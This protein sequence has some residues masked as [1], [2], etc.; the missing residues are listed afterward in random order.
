MTTARASYDL[1]LIIPT[2]DEFDYMRRSVPLSPISDVDKGYWFEFSLP[3]QRWGVAHV[4]FDMGLVTT[5]T[6]TGRLLARFSPD[7]LAVVGTGGGLSP[8]LALGDV[9]VGSVIQEYMKAAK[10]ASDPAKG[11][12]IKPSG[13]SW[14]LAE[15]LRNFANHFKYFAK[16]NHEDWL[17]FARIRA[18]EDDI[19]LATTPG[20]RRQP[21]YSLLPIASGDLVVTDPVFKDWLISHD[22]MRSVIEMEAAGAAHA[23]QAHDKGVAL[24]VLRGISDFADGQKSD[25]DLVASG[26]SDS[27]WRCYATQNAIELLLAF[28]ASPDFPWRQSAAIRP[29][30]DQPPAST[31]DDVA[32]SA[33][34]ATRR[35]WDHFMRAMPVIQAAGTAA[36]LAH[37]LWADHHQGTSEQHEATSPAADYH[38]PRPHDIR[39]GGFLDHRHIGHHAGH[40][41]HGDVLDAD[42]AD[43]GPEEP[44][45][46]GDASHSG[47]DHGFHLGGFH[48]GTDSH[49]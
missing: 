28:V 49:S 4:L 3:G 29:P 2:R 20:A 14:P 32:G 11:T 47:L 24:L 9:V 41:D 13:A 45:Y 33:W 22:R 46:A 34:S 39:P 23:V 21:D 19:P 37:E 44:W 6:A 16:Q 25:L 18:T 48:H 31:D 27:A 35:A 1:G 15:R 7:I 43:H 17:R 12:V 8:K 30:E 42:D 40:A 5:A 26:S 36:A 38:H 10:V